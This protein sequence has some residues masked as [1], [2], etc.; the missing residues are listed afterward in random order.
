MYKVSWQVEQRIILA[1]IS[2]DYST[3]NMVDCNQTIYQYLDEGNKPV[4]LIIQIEDLKKYPTELLTIKASSEKI[5]KHPAIGWM[6]LVGFNN[7]FARFL[8]ATVGQLSKLQFK[9][10][11]NL[12][13]ALQILRRVDDSLDETSLSQ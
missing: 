5:L 6:F 11:S 4:H 10:V 13:E 3:E 12:D 9:H 2:G 7:P 1:H 8:S